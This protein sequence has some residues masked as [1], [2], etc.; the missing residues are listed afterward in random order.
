MINYI[1]L[2]DIFTEWENVTDMVNND[3]QTRPI[4]IESWKRCKD[5]GLQRENLKFKILTNE[6]IEYKAKVNA[7]LIQASKKYIDNLSMSLSGIKHIIALSDKEGLIIDLRGTPNEFGGSIVGLCIGASWSECNIGNNGIGTCLT[8]NQPVLVYGVEHYV[9]AYSSMASIG[10]PI[11]YN[12]EVIGAL[13]ISVPIE[14]AHPYRFYVLL[15]CVQAI[16]SVLGNLNK[17]INLKDLNIS[18][19]SELIATAVHDLKNPL[20]VI[21]GLSQLGN[22]TTDNAKI[23]DYFT[24]IYKQVEEMNNMVFEIL[25]IFRPVELFPI[26]IVPIIE[27][28]LAFYKP[29][30]DSKNI[31]LSFINK[32]DAISSLCDN[33]FKRT[34]ENLINN[35]VQVMEENGTIEI[36]TKLESDSI[37]ILIKDSAGGIPEE[38]QQTIFEPFSF[39]RNGGT[40]LGLFMAYHTITNIHKGQIWYVT[41]QGKGSTFYI[42]LPV[43]V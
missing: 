8:L 7:Q 17:N 15:T 33:L 20:A 22:I 18:A 3:P 34:I 24:R 36:Q 39:R 32:E 14:Y 19:I 40:G 16:E 25:N 2:E 43:L 21:S 12:N 4:T 13:D 37:I 11:V 28:V 10:I 23:N 42:K 26:K 41:E 9:T 31:K 5:L 29:I 1:S 38:I 6:E 35:A 27:E 30:C